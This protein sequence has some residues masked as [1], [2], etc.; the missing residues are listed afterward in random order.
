[1]TQKNN[2]ILNL[3]EGLIRDGQQVSTI[4]IA[5]IIIVK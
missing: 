3:P 1:M 4:K 5:K 2:N